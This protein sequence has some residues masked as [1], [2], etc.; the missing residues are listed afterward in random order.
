PI[1]FL[2]PSCSAEH[3][4]CGSASRRS[5]RWRERLQQNALNTNLSGLFALKRYTTPPAIPPP[6]AADPAS[7][8]AA[9]AGRCVVGPKILEKE[10]RAGTRGLGPHGRS[11][12]SASPSRGLGTPVPMF[13]FTI[14]DL[15][16][17]MVVA[18]LEWGNYPRPTK[19]ICVAMI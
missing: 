5:F 9:L 17:L 15:L 12:A 6:H 16:W 13:R 14:R 18:E 4:L 7:H 19:G 10:S 3:S 2:A 11:R 1:D 8:P